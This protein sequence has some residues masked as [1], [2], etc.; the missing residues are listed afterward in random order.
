MGVE[1]VGQ[2]LLERAQESCDA[3]EF[4][5]QGGYPGFAASRAYYA[6]FYVAEALLDS[7]GLSFSRHSAVIA[8]FGREFCKTGIVPVDL[9]RHL[10]QAFELRNLGDYA[11]KGR[12]SADEAR[13]QIARARAMLEAARS[14][15]R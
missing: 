1:D 14:C 15:R 4:L 5:L 8:A 9:H 10:L 6:M 11:T 7:K 2:D 3:A 13:T 12:V